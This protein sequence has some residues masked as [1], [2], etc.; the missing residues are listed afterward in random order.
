MRLNKTSLLCVVLAASAIL[1]LVASI[2][3]VNALQATSSNQLSVTKANL[4]WERSYGGAADDRAFCLT[5]VG[6]GY[7]VAGSSQSEV[8]GRTVGWVLRLDRDGNVLWNRTYPEEGNGEIRHILSL[9]DGFLLVGNLFLPAGD[10]DGFVLR[11]DLE[12][13]LLWNLTLGGGKV[14]KL[15]SAV[16]TSDGF[17]LSGLT[18]S[19]G[20]GDSDAWVVKVDSAGNVVWERIYGEEAEEA[21]RAVAFIGVDYVVAG[22]SN[23]MGAENYDVL[24]LKLDA[25]GNIVWNSTHGGDQSDKAYAIATVEGRLVVAGDT[26]SKGMGD[27]DAWIIAVDGDSNLV[28]EKTVGGVDFDMPTCITASRDGGFLVGGFTFSFGSGKRDFW[29]F[30]LD[31]SGEVLWSCTQ[32]RD[33]YEEA[34]A[35]VEVAEN[36]FIMAGWE[37]YVEGGP[38]DY[39]IAKISHGSANE[40]FYGYLV[41]WFLFVAI[42]VLIAVFLIAYKLRN[43]Q[44]SK[45]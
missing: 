25:S 14:D 30:K 6:D 5:T 43:Q 13:E 10:I 9:A 22:Y 11:T 39:Y 44:T 27:S 24:L 12:G 16:S 40:W 34:Y 19:F 32:G 37:N 3:S 15:F 33:S 1:I 4:I 17:V 8:A 35:V 18:C 20:G 36:E 23:Y 28:W 21:A 2:F 29:L 31:G 38:Y 42:V 45:F 26:R 7:L 41:G